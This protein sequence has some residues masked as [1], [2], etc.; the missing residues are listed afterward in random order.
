MKRSNPTTLI[1]RLRS[2]LRFSCLLSLLL[3]CPLSKLDAVNRG[4]QSTGDSSDSN[5][6]TGDFGGS[7]G[8]SGSS[9]G[10][11]NGSN[12]NKHAPGNPPNGN[13][14]NNTGGDSPKLCSVVYSMEIGS[15][16]GES[17]FD[18]IE[19]KMKHIKPSPLIFT[20]QS[21][22]VS[23]LFAA[24][25]VQAPESMSPPVPPAPSLTIV[26]PNGKLLT[27]EPTQHLDAGNRLNRLKKCAASTSCQPQLLKNLL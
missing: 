3:L 17:G 8:S 2:C 16:Q 6:D 11:N 12:G 18:P 25:V 23:S 15:Y 27:F 22:E 4:T 20:P 24:D 21:L 1:Q 14:N 5:N 7:S 19:V 10:N 9:G 13:Q 26:R